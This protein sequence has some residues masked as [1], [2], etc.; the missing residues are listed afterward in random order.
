MRKRNLVTKYLLHG[1][2][3]NIL[4]MKSMNSKKIAI[5]CILFFIVII[6]FF[7]KISLFPSVVLQMLRIKQMEN[8]YC[9]NKDCCNIDLITLYYIY[10]TQKHVLHLRWHLGLQIF[11]IHIMKEK[12]TFRNTWSWLWTMCG[13]SIKRD[14]KRQSSKQIF[15]Q[16][17]IKS[18]YNTW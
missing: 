5:I 8:T 15:L 2:Y 18:A 17:Q 16:R 12:L 10:L 4:I 3:S 7:A 14:Q 9:S 6:W 1:C 11:N 13:I